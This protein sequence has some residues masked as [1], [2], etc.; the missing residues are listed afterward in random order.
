MNG[1]GIGPATIGGPNKSTADILQQVNCAIS[2]NLA[3]GAIAP[4]PLSFPRP[5]VPSGGRGNDFV[6][7]S[8]PIVG[9]LGS[10]EQQRQDAEQRARCRSPARA[11]CFG[12]YR[13]FNFTLPIAPAVDRIIGNNSRRTALVFSNLLGNAAIDITSLALPGGGRFR[14]VL[15]N[16]Y[17]E[18]RCNEIGAIVQSEWWGTSLD[19]SPGE[20][21]VY[22]MWD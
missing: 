17:V 21:R 12:K 18:L 3:L 11:A 2:A 15:P 9:A 4:M 13:V 20:F 7:F 8:D 6:A 16:E 5:I 1:C 14:F 22:E 10:A 19:P